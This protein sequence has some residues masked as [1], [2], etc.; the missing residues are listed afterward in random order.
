MTKLSNAKRRRDSKQSAWHRR[1][2]VIGA[3]SSQELEELTGKLTLDR[4]IKL[5]C[6]LH[7]LVHLATCTLAR[8]R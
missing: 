3:A 4:D 7:V 5:L 2:K 8:M 6:S 1:R